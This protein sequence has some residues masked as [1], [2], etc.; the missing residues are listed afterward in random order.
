MKGI[1]GPLG[2]VIRKHRMAAGL[3][4]EML[5]E[6]SGLHWTYVSQVERGKRNISVEALR[7]IGSALDISASTLLSEAE[8]LITTARNLMR[9]DE[10]S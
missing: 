4:Q 1:S 9:Y 8:Y 2:H 6:R 5:A 3:S 10:M 7:R